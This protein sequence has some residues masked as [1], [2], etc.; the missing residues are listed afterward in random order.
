MQ[1]NVSVTDGTLHWP[2]PIDNVEE[3]RAHEVSYASLAASVRELVDACVRTR[4][5]PDGAALVEG[6]V[7]A[8]TQELLAT[9]Q[10][11]PIGLEPCSDGRLR[12]HGNPVIGARNPCAPP[13]TIVRDAKSPPGAP[14]GAVTASS[15]FELGAP[16]E[17]P[18]GHVHGG[19]VAMILDQV[20]GT[21]PAMTG[22]PGMTAYLNLTYRRPTPLGQLSAHGWVE[23]KDGWKTFVKGEMRDAEGNVTVAADAL[24]IVPK[25]ARGLFSLPMSDAADFEPP[26]EAPPQ[27]Q[28][29]R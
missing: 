28:S 8:L 25:I 16:Y 17:G 13:L 22:S 9:S 3:L 2:F 19:M 10:A 27:E 29:P 20:L 26:T 12:G 24:F 21:L 11:G 15:S 6:R 5:S 14:E 18:P 4:V 1:E 23:S 7:R